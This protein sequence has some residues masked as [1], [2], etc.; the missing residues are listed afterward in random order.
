MNTTPNSVKRPYEGYIT[1]NILKNTYSYV[2][3]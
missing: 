2:P 1:L 3:P